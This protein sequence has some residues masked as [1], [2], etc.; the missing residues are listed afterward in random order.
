MSCTQKGC[1]YGLIL[2]RHKETKALF[3]FKCTCIYGNKFKYTIFEGKYLADYDYYDE[4]L[5]PENNDDLDESR[6]DVPF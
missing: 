3:T 1:D 6:D 2:L 4:F 5:R